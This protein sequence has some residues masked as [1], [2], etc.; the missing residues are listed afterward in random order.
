[1]RAAFIQ[2]LTR[3]AEN[4][5]RVVLLTG[6]LGYMALEPFANRFPKRFFNVGVAEQNMVGLAT[7]LAEDGF[8][9]FVYSIATFATLRGYEFIRHGPVL[10]RLPVRVVGVGG[11]FEYASNGASHHALEDLAVMRAQ[12]GMT[13]IA[14]A[15]AAQTERALADTWQL[16][17]P[18]YYRLGKN[19]TARVPGL[20]GDFQ[21]GRL[22]VL[23]S[24]KDI[25]IVTVGSIASEAVAAAELLREV[26]IQ[27]TV[28]IV[29]TVSPAP[30]HDLKAVLE[31]VRVAL[32]VE[33]HYVSGG[34]G[35]LVA[36]VVAERGLR[37]R[38]V[39]CGVSSVPEGVSGSE[40][41]LH[42][43]HG[44]SAECLFERARMALATRNAPNGA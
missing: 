35:S 9:P 15:D 34:L 27:V 33:A 22:V 42:Q 26:G 3:L 25:A 41:F 20:N 12:P 30:V 28:A 1:M 13:V 44:L 4:D 31:G 21:L 11:G 10:Q 14:P 37:C 29:S 40:A 38:L 36:E 6:D 19:D 2:T 16:A 39:R 24:G 7:G 5:G 43:L 23:G 18:V 17:G 8:L 32:T